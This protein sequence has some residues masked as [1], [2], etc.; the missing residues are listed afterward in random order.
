[1][2]NEFKQNIIINIY[3][4]FICNCSIPFMHITL[5]LYLNNNVTAIRKC[6]SIDFSGEKIHF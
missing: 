2:K 3:F 5:V 1:M 4:F 6:I